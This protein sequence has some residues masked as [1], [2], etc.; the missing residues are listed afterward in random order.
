MTRSETAIAKLTPETNYL[1]ILLARKWRLTVS[2]TVEQIIKNSIDSSTITLD[3]N[4]CNFLQDLYSSVNEQQ[5][6]RFEGIIKQ[7]E[8]DK[9][10][11]ND[12]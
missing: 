5:R 11:R 2:S 8:R 12:D 9:N 1:L 6:K 7:I 3:K 10:E 4:E